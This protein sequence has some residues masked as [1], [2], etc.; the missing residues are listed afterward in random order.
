MTV[1]I[2][3]DSLNTE[4]ATFDAEAMNKQIEQVIS[5]FEKGIKKGE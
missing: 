1:N 3:L 4:D 2:S 5:I